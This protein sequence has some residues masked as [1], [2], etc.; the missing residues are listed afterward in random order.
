MP[1]LG[2][3]KPSCITNQARRV[4]GSSGRAA[5]DGWPVVFTDTAGVRAASEPI[6]RAGVERSLNRLIEADL[7]LLVVDARLR[8][9]GRTRTATRISPGRGV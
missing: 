6:E 8:L 3:D 9:D 4:I 5:I 7:A 2:R 1:W